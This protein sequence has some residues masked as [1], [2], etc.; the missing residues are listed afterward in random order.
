MKKSFWVFLILSAAL[1]IF[2]VLNAEPVSV[3]VF[4]KEVHISLAI[5][6]IIVFMTG[7]IAGA[8]Y[9]FIKSRKKKDAIS[10]PGK[11]TDEFVMTDE[12]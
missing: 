5:L 9:F 3:N 4:F 10:E 11:D 2:S 7:V 8:S 1:V 6:L 12:D